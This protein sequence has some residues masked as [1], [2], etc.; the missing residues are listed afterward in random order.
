MLGL[1]DGAGGVCP[2]HPGNGSHPGH[3]VDEFSFTA[4]AGDQ[5][6]EGRSGLPGGRGGGAP[7]EVTRQG[8]QG[9][10]GAAP[11]RPGV[12]KEAPAPETPAYLSPEAGGLI[13]CARHGGSKPRECC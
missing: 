4:E 2:L 3:A 1:G 11:A 10:A 8:G 5:W 9:A 13:A 12:R 6:P 7:G